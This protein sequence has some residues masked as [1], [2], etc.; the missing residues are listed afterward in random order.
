MPDSFEDYAD[1]N[2]RQTLF[3][4]GSSLCP[5]IALA[6]QHTSIRSFPCVAAST[7]TSSFSSTTSST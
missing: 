6:N 1:D 5:E 3:W 4:Q 7:L 2:A